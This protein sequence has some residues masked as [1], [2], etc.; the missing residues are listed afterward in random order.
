MNVSVHKR[1]LISIAVVVLVLVG[2]VGV[3]VAT[4]YSAFFSTITNGRQSKLDTE[5]QQYEKEVALH[6]QRSSPYIALSALYLQKIRET[7][8]SSYYQKI[9]DLLTQ[10]EK[11]N[12]QDA[13]IYG[14]RASVANGRHEFKKGK[15]YI[16]KA[17]ALNTTTAIYFGIAGD[18]A[19]ELGQYDQAVS[20][21]QKMVDIRPD[22][23]S[24]SRIAY[25]RE[26]YGDTPGAQKALEQAIESGSKYPENLAWAYVEKGKLDLRTDPDLAKSDF[27]TALKVLPTYSQAMEGLGKAAYA[28]GNTTE[29]EAQFT[30]AYAKLPL[31]QYAIDLGDLYK[32][33]GQAQKASQYYTLAQQAYATSAKLGVNIDLEESLFLSERDIKVSDAL[34]MA[35]RSYVDRPNRNAADTLAIALFKNN[36]VEEA[37]TYRQ[38][39]F[40]LGENDPAILYNQSVIARASGKQKLADEYLSKSRAL[41]P[42]FSILFGATTTKTKP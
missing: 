28:T 18:S 2:A 8:D 19:I 24:W 5:I 41:N 6:P 36:K 13:D 4:N 37:G 20:Y 14:M 38:K 35:Q 12:P 17:L 11:V 40:T 30:K 32:I 7:S 1:K 10:A 21:F 9:D 16:D 29:A 39:A 3:I 25:A 42:N 27:S 26:L 34:A 22:F 23:G 31:A 15:E 33:K